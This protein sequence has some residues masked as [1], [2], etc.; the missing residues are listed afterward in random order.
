MAKIPSDTPENDCAA[1]DDELISLH[2]DSD[3]ENAQKSIVFNARRDLEDPKFEFALNMIF[4]NSKEFKWAVEMHAVMKKKD[5]NFKKNESRRARAVCKVS[6][7]KWFIHASKANEDE[8]FKIKTIGPDHSCANQRENK[9][10][11]SGFLA[12][13]YVE[14]FRINPS[15]GVKEFQAHVMRKHSST[16]SRHQSYRAKRK[17]LDLITGTKEEQ[18]D[19]LWDYCAELK[20]SN[21]GTTCILKLDDNPKTMVKNRKRFLGLYVC[22][23]ACK[24]GFLAGCRPVIGVDG[25]HLKGYQ[26]GGQL[27]T[28]VGIGA[29]NNMYPIAFAIVE[30][31]L[32]ETWSWFL[33][34]LNKDLGISQNSFAWTFISDKQKGLI[35]AFDETIPDVAHRFCVR[36]LH[37]N[38]K[39]EGFGGQALKDVLW[40][41]ARATTEP[42]FSKCMEEMSKIDIEA[43]KWFINK[44]PIHWSRAFFSSFTKCDVIEQYV[45]VIK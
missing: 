34:L 35:L 3:D 21:P 36:H 1:S 43:P 17:A 23:A 6:S 45:R 29:N 10:I 30:G 40:K 9:T 16:L 5:I 32:K 28:A 7:C 33:T 13:K 8:P 31:E 22:F 2:G 12:K 26:K 24:Q 20:R 44:P 14:E 19:M 11:D 25:C 42:E 41:A 37:R 4:S 38:F 27:L 18:F 15:W 39:T